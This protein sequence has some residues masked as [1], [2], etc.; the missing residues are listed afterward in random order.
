M[1]GIRRPDRSFLVG[2]ALGIA[3]IGLCAAQAQAKVLPSVKARAPK[4]EPRARLESAIRRGAAAA[5][6]P[7]RR[8]PL[9]R[10]RS[11]RYRSRRRRH[12]TGAARQQA[13]HHDARSRPSK[14]S[15]C[16][17]AAICTGPGSS[18]SRPAS[19]ATRVTCAMRSSVPWH[20]T[21]AS[22]TSKSRRRTS[23]LSTPE[24]PSAARAAR[25]P[26]ASNSRSSTSSAPARSSAS[27][28]SPD[29]DRDSKLI[30]FRDRQ[31]GSSWWDLDTGYSDNSDGRL[32]GVLARASVLF[33]RHPLGRRACR[34]STT[35]A[36]T[37]ATTWARSST[38]S[39]THEKL[40]DYLLGPVGRS[41]GRLGAP[42]VIRPDLRRPCLRRRS[43]RGHR[44]GAA[45]VRPHARVSVDR[46]RVGRGRV[47]HRAQSRPDRED[48]GLLARLARTRATG[49]RQPSRSAP[50]ATP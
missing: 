24:S 40:L 42:P 45:A 29:V 26:R 14:I 36:P 4:P 22:S 31:L 1:V 27:A 7:H 32:G 48:R 11:V 13:A 17:R 43:G 8:D 25:T 34:C 19:C 12:V 16:S 30:H 49:L 9:R 28:S 10:A 18:K 5:G 33:A 37:P 6:R 35:S 44:A 3:L 21:T 23:G 46:R 41:A 15:C 38:S 39:Q 50:I 2:V 47:L 20:F